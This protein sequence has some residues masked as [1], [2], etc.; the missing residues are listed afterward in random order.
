MAVWKRPGES[1]PRPGLVRGGQRDACAFS[2]KCTERLSCEISV[3]ED[4]DCVVRRNIVGWFDSIEHNRWLSGHMQASSKRQKARSSRLVSRTSMPTESPIRPDR[5]TWLSR[6][7]WPMCSRS[8]LSWVCPARAATP[9]MPSRALTNYFTDPVNGGMWFA[10]KPEPD[11]DGRGVP[12]D[13][14]ARVKSQYHT[15]YALLG[16]AAATVANRPRSPRA[17]QPHARGAEGAVGRRLRPRV[18]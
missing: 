5:L 6:V 15:V 13:E 16:V 12:W 17:A 2:Q 9:T 4:R 8:E 3:T 10:I 1:A 11:A 7:A 14:D 18:G